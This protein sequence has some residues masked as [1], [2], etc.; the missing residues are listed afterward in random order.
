MPSIATFRRRKRFLGTMPVNLYPY[1]REAVEELDSG[2]ILCAGVGLGKSITALAY[3]YEKECG[4]KI[5]ED[6]SLEPMA[7]PKSLRIITTAHK[8]DSGEW[9]E[10]LTRFL[11][12]TESDELDIL[13]DSWNNLHKHVDDK[14]AFF[15]FDEQRVVGSG[16]WVKAFLAVAEENRWILL[17]ATPGD[18]WSDYI[19]VFIANGFYKNRSQFLKRHAVFNRFCKYPKIDRYVE[20]GRLEKFRKQITVEMHGDHD[21]DKYHHEVEIG[22]DE[23]KYKAVCK[24]RWNC[25]KDQPIR[26]AGELC[27]VLRRVVNDSSERIGKMQELLQRPGLE[28][29]IIFYNF[30]YELEAL[31]SMC[32]GIEMTFAEWNGHK[33]EPLPESER[34]VYLVQYAAGAEGWNCVSTNVVVFYSLNYS[35]KMMTQAAGRIDRVN[36]EYNDLHYVYLVTG[37]SIDK[38][39]K[40]A[41]LSK[42][43]FNELGFAEKTSYIVEGDTD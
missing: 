6:G 31:R 12:S 23:E 33:H 1:Q 14:G 10:E 4:G 7:S 21:I 16:S 24:D 15:I 13:V 42:K 27:Y 37:S 8:R 41:L 39:I 30:D 25:Y 17:S 40:S 2:K 26:D 34:W 20:T 18:T 43:N 28:R 22:Y 36:T 32:T 3:Y 9:E 29:A 19:P 38:S 5:D 35:Y 11:L